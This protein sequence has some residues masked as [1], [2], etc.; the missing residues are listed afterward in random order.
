MIDIHCHILPGID[1]GAKNLEDAL[2]MAR[3][4]EEDGIKKIINTSH[5]HPEFDYIS[6]DKLKDELDKF[7]NI[8]KKEKIDLEIIIGNEIYFDDNYF[9]SIDKKG[10]YTLGDSKYILIEFSPTRFPSKLKE[11][12]YEFK[13]KGYTPILAHIERYSQIQKNPSLVKEAVQEGALIQLNGPSIIGK[14]GSEIQ[15]L[16]ELLLKNNLIHFVAS[17]AH[18]SDRRRPKLKEVYEYIC[19][20][21]SSELANRLI[22]ENPTKLLNNQEITIE[23][24]L[25]EKVEKRGF[26]SKL[27]KK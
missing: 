25:E 19:R 16:S 20:N 1:D 8:L 5:Y 9:S 27:F 7:N 6:G 13:I 23:E 24:I 3:I 22:I 10:F 14:S 4:A 11:V 26:F 12:I 21:Y 17:D 2:E 15:K 18:S